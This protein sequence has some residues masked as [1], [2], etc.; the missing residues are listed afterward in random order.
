M[1]VAVLEKDSVST[2][3][4]D[5]SSLDMAAKTEYFDK[6]DAGTLERIFAEFDGI[7]VNKTKIDGRLLKK[8]VKLNLI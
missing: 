6:I 2:G 5:F 3:D 1:R 7:V 4:I 8:S